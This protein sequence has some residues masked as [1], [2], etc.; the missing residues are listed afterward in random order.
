MRGL[1]GGLDPFRSITLPSYC[2]KVYRTLHMPEQSI[3]I[4]PPQGY[5]TETYSQSAI[6]WVEWEALQR[7]ICIRH[8]RNSYEIK[9]GP[10][11]V[12][13]YA[14]INGQR[15]V[16]EYNGC[17]RFFASCLLLKLESIV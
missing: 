10:C 14:L 15:T 2:N 6:C 1:F 7:G 8:A 9:V 16:F 11:K 17:V 4:L 12:D 13:G 3:A 5:G